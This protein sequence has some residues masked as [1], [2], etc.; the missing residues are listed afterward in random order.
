MICGESVPDRIVWS[1]ASVLWRRPPLG[2]D[3]RLHG[4]RWLQ[5]VTR[6]LAAGLLYYLAAGMA[7]AGTPALTGGGTGKLLLYV[8]PDGHGMRCSE[9]APCSIDAVQRRLRTV[10][11]RSTRD[12]VIRLAPGTYELERPIWLGNQ[13][14][15]RRGLTV[16]W[17][18]AD[19]G[20][21]VLSGGA[22]VTGWRVFDKARNIWQAPLPGG[23]LATSRMYVNGVPAQLDASEPC[24]ATECRY[25]SSGIVGA[26]RWLSSVPPNSGATISAHVRWRYFECPLD[27]TQSS[28]A[29][30]TVTVSRR[31][32]RRAALQTQTG[33]KHSSPSGYSYTGA[34]VFR[35]ALALLRTPGTFYVDPRS[36]TIYYIPRSNEHLE[37]A[38]T[39]VPRLSTLVSIF[40]MDNVA[41]GITFKRITFEYTA[42][43]DALDPAGYVGAQAGW[44]IPDN[45]EGE[46]AGS[47]DYFVRPPAAVSVSNG[48]GVAFNNDTFIHLGAAGIALLQGT[49]NSAIESDTFRDIGSTAIMVGGILAYPHPSSLKG[50]ANSILCNQIERSGS[51]YPDA[52]AIWAGYQDGIDIGFNTITDIPY[53]GISVGWGWNFVGSGVTSRGFD[54]HNN[55]ISGFMKKMEDGA[56][57][58]TQG[59]DWASSINNNVVSFN[60]STSDAYGIYLDERSRYFQVSHNVVWN[61]GARQWFFAWAPYS[62][63]NVVFE[64][65][66]DSD[67]STN[68]SPLNFIIRGANFTSLRRMPPDADRVMRNAGVRAVFCHSLA[69]NNARVR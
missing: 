33:W 60:G 21:T 56:A 20:A 2:G 51:M 17:E 7:V 18:G 3:R 54:I 25:T 38:Q 1:A 41:S 61:A 24:Y 9:G 8:A 46:L 58:Y 15:T 39:V 69:M 16:T 22:S 4:G 45:A 59:E 65:W 31:C 66:T 57:I 34:V 6:A 42:W 62:A 5:L 28:Q 19:D 53:T 12:I 68:G 37:T 32:W 13:P 49:R 30:T 29:G 47:G 23:V 67:K 64:N 10:I 50:G 36:R 11:A 26:P 14:Y 43:P 55:Y 35:N 52:V 27:A 48:D 44:L 63:Y 40:G